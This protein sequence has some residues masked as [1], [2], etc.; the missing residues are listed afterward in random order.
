[1]LQ[2]RHQAEQR[3]RREAAGSCDEPCALE[4]LSVELWK[5]VDGLLD[6]VRP[7]VGTVPVLVGRGIPQPKVRRQI[8]YLNSRVEQGSAKP[9]ARRVGQRREG[10]VDV[11]ADCI[12][13]LEAFE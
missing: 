5:P 11:E 13:L 8:N 12:G 3:A 6:E 1:R 10:D 9:G 4:L 7:R 2:E